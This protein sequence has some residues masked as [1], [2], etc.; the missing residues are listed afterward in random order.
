MHRRSFLAYGA[1]AT[2]SY[3]L[4]SLVACAHRNRKPTASTAAVPWH[5]LVAE[6]E[7]QTPK[8]MAD[9]KVPGVSIAAIHNAKIV[10]RRG[11]G[12]ADAATK[13]PVDQDTVFQAASMSKP[14]FAYVALKLCE[15]DVIGLDTPLTKYAPEPFLTGDP[16]IELITPR[17]ILSHS[18]GFQN[19]RSQEDH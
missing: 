8:L 6:F 15:K 16:R 7:A 3:S 10:W 5:P 13:A 2:L 11:F 9:A 17:H 1:K 18:S 14:V 12:F 19:W 4:I